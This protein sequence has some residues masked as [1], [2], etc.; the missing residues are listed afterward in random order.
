ME[1]LLFDAFSGG[2]VSVLLFV[3]S[4]PKLCVLENNYFSWK[5]LGREET[6][7]TWLDE[8]EKENKKDNSKE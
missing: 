3:V 6:G 5:N 1:A 7:V 2:I 4:L 8:G